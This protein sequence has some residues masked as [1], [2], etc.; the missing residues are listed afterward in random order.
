MIIRKAN[1]ND[2]ELIVS[3]ALN[4]WETS[5]QENYQENGFN[6]GMGSIPYETWVN[7]YENLIS[8]D[9]YLLYV[10]ENKAGEVIGFVAAGPERYGALHYKGEIYAIYVLKRYQ[11]KGV[12]NFLLRVIFD[13][14]KELGIYSVMVLVLANNP[15]RTFYEKYGAQRIIPGQ[16]DIKHLSAG[17]YI[18][19]WPDIRNL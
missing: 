14:F 18:Y 19:G 16:E 10:A 9:N 12:G 4:T 8:S 11:R 5:Y 13:R 2:I 6:N 1:I 17:L 15:C 7:T 3:V